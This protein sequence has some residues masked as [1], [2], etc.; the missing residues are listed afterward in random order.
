MSKTGGK[1]GSK[2]KRER[3]VE[4][5]SS[6]EGQKEGRSREGGWHRRKRSSAFWFGAL[7]LLCLVLWTPP[8]IT[9]PQLELFFENK[10]EGKHHGQ[11][12]MPVDFLSQPA[13]YLRES[14]PTASIRQKNSIRPITEAQRAWKRRNWLPKLSS[15]S[16]MSTSQTTVHPSWAPATSQSTLCSQLLWENH[17]ALHGIWYP[18]QRREEEDAFQL[19][20]SEDAVPQGHMR[21]NCDSEASVKPCE[22]ECPGNVQN[23]AR[24]WWARIPSEDTSA[25]WYFYR[26]CL[27][28]KF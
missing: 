18:F 9:T 4:K 12:I 6:R 10:V 14:C 11:Q 21:G 7:G 13:S 16:L 15:C 5:G 23:L 28:F 25:F 2:K 17:T 19:W 20:A 1:K 24:V 27:Y 3:G 26:S 22:G 8:G